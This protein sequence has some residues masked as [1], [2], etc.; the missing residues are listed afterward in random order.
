MTGLIKRITDYERLELELQETEERLSRAQGDLE[1]ARRELDKLRS[2]LESADEKLR[3]EHRRRSEEEARR[4]KVERELDEKVEEIEELRSKVKELESLASRDPAT[5]S[6]EA[7][8][9]VEGI[10]DFVR[11]RRFHSPGPCVSISLPRLEAVEW[12]KVAPGMASWASRIVTDKGL[13]AYAC[14]AKVVVLEPPLPVESRH[15]GVGESFDFSLLDPFVDRPRVGFVSLH[16]DMYAVCV[17]DNGVAENKFEKKSVVGRSKKGGFSQSRYS[18]SREDQVKH[19]I[20]EVDEALYEVFKEEPPRYV[21]L[22]GDDVMVASF[23]DSAESLRP[24]EVVRFKMKGKL[25]RDLI[26]MLP[27]LVWKWRAWVLDLPSPMV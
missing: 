25:S 15:R 14:G 22:E 5:L 16:R 10:P 8:L 3:R 19:L 2:Q 23:I 9:E 12:L 7:E 11:E 17:L 6:K 27:D 20:S 24:Y 4:G 13:V 18:R 1:D 26:E 21:L